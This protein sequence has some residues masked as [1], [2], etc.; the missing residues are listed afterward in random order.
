MGQLAGIMSFTDLMQVQKKVSSKNLD[1][2][3]SEMHVAR[4]ED[5]TAELLAALQGGSG[6]RSLF[7]MNYRYQDYAAQTFRIGAQM[8]VFGV[9]E[10]TPG[11]TRSAVYVEALLGKAEDLEGSAFESYVFDRAYDRA[12]D[13]SAMT[14]FGAE[15]AL[16]AAA[17]PEV[18][19][20]L[21][22]EEREAY[23][24]RAADIAERLWKVREENPRSRFVIRMEKA[25]T[26]SAK[27]LSALYELLPDLLRRQIGFM[28]NIAEA[29][30]AAVMQHDLP[31]YVFT[32]D[33]EETIDPGKFAFPVIFYDADD[34]S[35]VDEADVDEGRCAA[36]K[37]LAEEILNSGRISLDEA[38]QKVLAENETM[39]P[40]FKY[41]PDILHIVLN[42]GADE[43]GEDMEDLDEVPYFE[44]KE[45][46]ASAGIPEAAAVSGALTAAEEARIAAEAAEKAAED[47][48]E[49]AEALMEAQKEYAAE[50]AGVVSASEA[51]RAWAGTDGE[52]Y[53]DNS[54]VTPDAGDAADAQDMWQYDADDAGVQGALHSGDDAAD[55]AE[56]R[57]VWQADGDDVYRPA[58]VMDAEDGENEFRESVIADAPEGDG[59]EEN[60]AA[61][62]PVPGKTTKKASLKEEIETLR[63]KNKNLLKKMRRLRKTCA[64]LAG[65]A[66]AL[67]VA[68]IILGGM[69]IAKN[70]KAKTEDTASVPQVTSEAEI[71]QSGAE[72][73]ETAPAGENAVSSDAAVPGGENSAAGTAE[74]TASG[75]ES[76]GTESTAQDSSAAEYLAESSESSEESAAAASGSDWAVVQG[77]SPE[78]GIAYTD[79]SGRLGSKESYD[80]HFHIMYAENEDGDGISQDDSLPYIGAYV[81]TPEADNTDPQYYTWHKADEVPAGEGLMCTWYDNKDFVYYLHIAYAA[82]ESGSDFST[83]DASGRS[84]I[85]YLIDNQAA[86]STEAG[87]YTWIAR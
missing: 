57:A 67:L 80:V 85:G 40:S 45:R 4:P 48:A 6:K 86:D 81:S 9:K 82:D 36:L 2:F 72:N 54:E 41:L 73:S 43:D 19:S 24:N 23:L 10:L 65:I 70:R 60:P 47:R 38:E 25:E 76:A 58:D 75:A 1:A 3:F 14:E 56:D 87:N 35:P 59:A 64:V 69:L 21:R 17:D 7:Y 27:L 11:I 20:I 15:A 26:E 16:T 83:E 37:M 53:D 28:T 52:D 29:D 31:I 46:G 44:K 12:E 49:R 13:V 55:A 77:A 34:P 79:R 51:F 18:V 39:V 50:E 8:P 33:Y 66:A 84:Y 62:T 61:Q 30:L 32:A 63:K 78:N 68:C 74:S 71:A 42:A 22:N 5:L